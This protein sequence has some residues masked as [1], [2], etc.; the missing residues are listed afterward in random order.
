M[1]N[2]IHFILL[3]PESKKYVK[4]VQTQPYADGNSDHNPVLMELKL[5]FHKT[6]TLRTTKQINTE[7]L[8]NIGVQIQI[9]VPNLKIE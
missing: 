5:I 3:K 6:N 1:R 9:Q 2:Q 7:N 4:F 8:G